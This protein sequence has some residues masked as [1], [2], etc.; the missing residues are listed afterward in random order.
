MNKNM[1]I[2]IIGICVAL[3]I[4]VVAAAAA[5]N[6]SKGKDSGSGTAAGSTSGAGSV[7]SGG[8]DG[9]GIAS[10]GNS[11]S[12][13]LGHDIHDSHMAGE[14]DSLSRY[15]TEQDSIMMTMMEDM[16]IREKSGNASIDFL[17]G[18][19]P[20]HD[21]AVKMAQ[22][23]LN[24]GAENEELIALAQDIITSQK[25]DIRQMNGLLKE[26]QEDGRKDQEKEDAYLEQY[27]KMFADDSMS[28]HM[29]SSHVKNV[30]QA[31]A[32]GMVMHHQMA[33]DMAEDIL[34]YTDY[35]EI[36]TLAQGIIDTQEKE[37]TQ[38]Q[39]LSGQQ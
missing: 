31:F 15:I 3:L 36:K 11:S 8:M 4:I 32:E 18:M 10:P 19:I 1:R 30:D 39:R 21:S 5:A 34:E 33:V 17:K 7:P 6:R 9:T 25:E 27:S 13:S 12:D 14:G 22:S 16:L 24:H 2:W 28:H 35:E 38:M 29:D 37:I 23:Y 26:Y 20:H